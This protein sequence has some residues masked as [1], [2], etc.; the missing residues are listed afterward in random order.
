VATGVVGIIRFVL[1]IS[2]VVISLCSGVLGA[3]GLYVYIFKAGILVGSNTD[4]L[5]LNWNIHNLS[6]SRVIEEVTVHSA[7]SIVLPIVLIVVGF[8]TMITQSSMAKRPLY[9]RVRFSRP[10]ESPPI[11][12]FLV[13]VGVIATAYVI[14]NWESMDQGV[15]VLVI[16]A[17]VVAILWNLSIIGH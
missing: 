3:H 14:A 17:N 13:I 11:A 1:R 5:F 8:L 16:A 7:E 12:L 9:R 10:T 6:I 2:L 4:R 15:A